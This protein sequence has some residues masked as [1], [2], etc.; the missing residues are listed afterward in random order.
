MARV[1]NI[2]NDDLD[3]I[4][5]GDV[6]DGYPDY[7]LVNDVK[8]KK[9][10][11]FREEGLFCLP[12]TIED[13][14]AVQRL[15]NV[16]DTYVFDI[17][18]AGEIDKSEFNRSLTG[19]RTEDSI[20]YD[21]AT[22]YP[23]IT[24]ATSADF[25]NVVTLVVAETKRDSNEDGR[26]NVNILE[27]HTGS[28]L[29]DA[30]ADD[31][32]DVNGG[33]EPGQNFYIG[34]II[35]K[36]SKYIRFYKN[37]KDTTPLTLT[38]FLT[39]T[40]PEDIRLLMFSPQK[41]INTSKIFEYIDKALKIVEYMPDYQIDVIA[42]AGLSTIAMGT[43]GVFNLQN[44]D[45]TNTSPWQAVCERYAN[46]CSKVRKDCMAVLDVPRPMVLRGEHPYIKKTAP[47]N[48][49]TNTIIP[50]TNYLNLSINSYAALYSNWMKM[51]D[52][53]SGRNV[54]MPPTCKV[55]GIYIRSDKTGDAGDPPA[56]PNVGQLREIFDLSFYPR[57]EEADLIY[58][59]NLN[60]ATL[61][62]GN[63]VLHGHKTWSNMG[64][65]RNIQPRRI[66]CRIYRVVSEV[67][68]YFI[69][70]PNNSYTRRTIVSIIEEILQ[71]LKN[72]NALYDYKIVCD[73]TNNTPDVIDR[74][75]L[76]IEAALKFTRVSEF[77]LVDFIAV[78]TS[79]DFETVII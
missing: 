9:V 29:K 14:L 10:G 16:D 13:A 1:Y 25:E 68:K 27:A 15:S 4:L 28:V 75:E 58:R 53:F 36:N 74:N 12:V 6:V 7:F 39:E 47:Q 48:T 63:F 70:E 69:N 2:S 61:E 56:G 73:E 21:F 35:N 40:A 78:R 43:P 79:Q 23:S 66:M 19:T 37:G 64:V 57:Q 77:I 8:A 52:E 62:S 46:F 17:V 49:I 67:I 5:N 34:D 50:N 71:F 18:T 54:W 22:M 31:G 24:A 60:Y 20:S 3:S 55:I 42:D 65:F 41:Y 33:M 45:I 30:T 44:L 38:K 59:K 72:E 51:Y 76:V 11:P 26:L 32:L